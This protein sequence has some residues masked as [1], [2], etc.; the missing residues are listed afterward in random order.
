MKH[1]EAPE[2]VCYGSLSQITAFDAD[3]SPEDFFY[4]SQPGPPP[5]DG[6]GSNN[7]CVTGNLEDCLP[8]VEP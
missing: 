1:Y 3:D 2:L 8:D 7:G 5:I 6:T 4:Y